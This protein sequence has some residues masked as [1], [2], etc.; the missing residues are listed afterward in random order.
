M[1]LLHVGASPMSFKDYAVHQHDC[2][3]II[4]NSEGTGTAMMG[5]EEY[6]FS[7]GTIHIVHPKM[8]HNKRSPEGFR[9]KYI[10]TDSLQGMGVLPG[11]G[12]EG[13]AGGSVILLIDD[14]CHTAEGLM[15]ILLARY[16]T[17]AR[18]DAVTETLF[19][20]LLQHLGQLHQRKPSDPVVNELIATITASYNNPEFQVT[21]ALLSTG[22]SKDHIRRR[23]YQETGMTPGAYLRNVRMDYA[24]K[25]LRQRDMLHLPVKEIALLCGY[26][27]VAYFCRLF[28][29]ETGLTP[30]EYASE[31]ER[32]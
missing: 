24:K 31:S 21:E 10:H 1:A 28:H 22:Y 32:N 29:K 30:T 2:Y 3:E 5:G 9:D 12:G 15:S 16:L 7:P 26:Y 20:A 4:L 18:V 14:A 25:M 13:A 8:P 11:T 27:D 17:S 19:D 23:F 6:P